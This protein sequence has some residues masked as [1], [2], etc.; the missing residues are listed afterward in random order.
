MP[1][2]RLEAMLHTKLA[3]TLPSL[4]VFDEGI[5]HA[6]EALRIYESL[7][8]LDPENARTR[9]DVVNAW[10]YRAESFD[11]KASEKRAAG[12]FREARRGYRNALE[13]ARRL[14]KQMPGHPHLQNQAAEIAY[15][16][17]VV[18]RRL[19]EAAAARASFEEARALTIRVADRAEAG[20]T[21]LLRAA[22]MFSSEELPPEWRDLPRARRYAERLTAIAQSPH[23]VY[24]LARICRLQGRLDEARA[25][26][27][28]AESL[29]PPPASG[30]PRSY[31]RRQIEDEKR[32]ISSEVSP[33]ARAARGE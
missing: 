28:R 18:S 17:A 3:A 5:A 33:P 16:I 32:A 11:Y 2:L 4:G 24:T 31:L 6:R 21:Q 9:L 22:I 1:N 26:I 15:R 30:Q 12:D 27:A 10:Y 8:A 14:L 7:A 29:L 13:G 25:A 23:G 20:E 19:G